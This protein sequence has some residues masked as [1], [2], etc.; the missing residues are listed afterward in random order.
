MSRSHSRS[1]LTRGFC[2]FLLLLVPLLAPGLQGPAQ[3]QHHT[4]KLE[5]EQI[6]NLEEQWRAATIAGDATAMDKLLAED[7]VGISWSGQV[8][9]KAMQ[10]DRIRNH[11]LIVRQMDLSDIKIKVV[12]PV[13]IVTSRAH[14]EGTNDGSDIKGDFRYTRVYQRVPSGAWKITNFEATRIPPGER[15]HH[16]DP[17]VDQK[18]PS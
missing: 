15:M 16:H 13:A 2:R 10:L 12:G 18:N 9:T 14:V 8:N 3:A 4:P 6:Q 17:P 7:F 1:P 5:K 11:A